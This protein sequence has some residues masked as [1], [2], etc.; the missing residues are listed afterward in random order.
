MVTREV[1]VMKMVTIAYVRD[2]ERSKMIYFCGIH[3]LR[4]FGLFGSLKI[5]KNANFRVEYLK[6]LTFVSEGHLG[7][8]LAL[9]IHLNPI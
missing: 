3:Y 2:Y 5:D 7:K 6:M 1:A 4:I 8:K 9:G